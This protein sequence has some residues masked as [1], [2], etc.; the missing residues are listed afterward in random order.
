MM[1]ITSIA[2]QSSSNGLEIECVSHNAII[3]NCE[4]DHS[5]H[6]EDDYFGEFMGWLKVQLHQPI[7]S[8]IQTHN[9]ICIY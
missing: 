8:G 7:S 6:C 1:S 4:H 5:M 2:I 3:M 9:R